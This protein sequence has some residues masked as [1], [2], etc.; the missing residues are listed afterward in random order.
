LE[1]IPATLAEEVSKMLEI[2]TIGIGAGNKTDGQVLVVNDM[3]G[4]TQEFKP[5]FLRQ[6]LNLNEEINNA[7]K[8]Y[9]SDVKS[10]D[11]PN[12]SEQY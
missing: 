7:V 1:K 2:P 3:L 6:Y 10:Q 4:I 11:Y 8:Q 9:I 5:K 12:E